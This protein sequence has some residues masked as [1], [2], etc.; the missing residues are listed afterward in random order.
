MNFQEKVKGIEILKKLFCIIAFAV[1]YRIMKH[2]SQLFLNCFLI[3]MF[4][5]I[6]GQWL[7]ITRKE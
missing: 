4:N 3:Q 7:S 6:R 1:H 5:Y 2:I